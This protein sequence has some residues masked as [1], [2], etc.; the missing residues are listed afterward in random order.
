MA[1]GS[2]KMSEKFSFTLR[3]MLPSLGTDAA[4][5]RIAIRCVSTLF[6]ALDSYLHVEAPADDGYL[7]A[8][9]RLRVLLCEM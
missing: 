7:G 5:V 8:M 6:T 1:G 3:H 9:R 2:I 4:G